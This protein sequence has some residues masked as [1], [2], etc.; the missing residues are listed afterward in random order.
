MA[1]V[2]AAAVKA[3]NSTCIC[4]GNQRPPAFATPP[5]LLCCPLPS[6]L[7]RPQA[8]QL[9]RAMAASSSNTSATLTAVADVQR[10]LD[11]AVGERDSLAAQLR[12]VQAAASAAEGARERAADEAEREREE[13]LALQQQLEA[14]REG[15]DEGSASAAAADA[16]VAGLQVCRLVAGCGAAQVSAREL[17]LFAA[18]TVVWLIESI[19][20][21]CFLVPRS[22]SKSTLPINFAASSALPLATAA[23]SHQHA[24]GCALT[25]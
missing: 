13:R 25:C 16:R 7:P 1:E 10:L 24:A 19:A 11:E 3:D 20:A 2:A 17:Q 23:G 22:P 9:R 15:L 5:C 12:E 8:R 14:L 21:G 6:P 4:C 18:A